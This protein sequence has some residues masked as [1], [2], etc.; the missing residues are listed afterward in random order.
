MHAGPMKHT[1]VVIALLVAACATSVPEGKVGLFVHAGSGVDRDVLHEGLYWHFP[2]NHIV[3]FPSQ[4]SDYAEQ[5]HVLTADDV[6]LDV[7]G[8]I[9]IRPN[10]NELYQLQQD[11]GIRYYDT[12]VQSA[13]FTATRTVLAHYNMVDIPE[14][15]EKIE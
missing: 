14:N 2:W 6:H 12:I 3:M 13:F 5:M 7:Q 15:S 10:I 11:L 9:A 1:S 8:G 4:W